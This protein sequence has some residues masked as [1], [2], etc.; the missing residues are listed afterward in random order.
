VDF[1]FPANR[2][3]IRAARA[4]DKLAADY[5]GKLSVCEAEAQANAVTIRSLKLQTAP[6]VVVYRDGKKVETLPGARTEEEYRKILDEHLAGTRQ[7]EPEKEPPKEPP[8][9]PLVF[10]DAK[11]AGDFAAKTEKAKGLVLVDFHAEWCGWCR[12][13]APVLNKL[14]ADYKGKVVF[15]GVDADKSPDL[16]DKFGVEGLPTMV[17]FKDGKPVETVAGF[18]KEE[19]LRQILDEHVAGTRKVEP[20]P[21]KPKAGADKAG[22]AGGS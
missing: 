3:C 1:H 15:V 18:R 12:L 22:S 14:S 11:D 13:L 2:D 9:V 6:T 10:A 17:I 19:E 8:N 16:K 20:E 21:A 5:K 7:V 4:L